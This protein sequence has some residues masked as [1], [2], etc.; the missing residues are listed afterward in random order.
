VVRRVSPRIFSAMSQ[1]ATMFAV[2]R[3]WIAREMER[4]Y[5]ATLDHDQLIAMGLPRND[6]Q[7]EASKPFWRG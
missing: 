4:Q 1:I 5:L 2:L 6:V 3:R 7:R